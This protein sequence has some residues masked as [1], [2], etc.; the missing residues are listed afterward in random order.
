MHDIFIS[1]RHDGG[2]ETAKFLHDSLTRDGYS[3]AFDIDTLRNGRFDKALL[4]RIDEC[5]DF[6]VI[7]SKGC[8]DRTLNSSYP[9]ENDWLRIE[10]AHAL[11]SK[12]N[13]IPIMLGGFEFPL[14]LPSDISNVALMNGPKYS[15]E[16]FDAFYKKMRDRFLK[17][18]CSPYNNQVDIRRRFGLWR[19]VC[20]TLPLFVA[21]CVGIGVF[22]HWTAERRGKDSVFDI[23]SKANEQKGNVDLI[24]KEDGFLPLVEELCGCFAKAELLY[25]EGKWSDA[26]IAYTNYVKRC[27]ELVALDGERQAAKLAESQARK[28]L[29]RASVFDAK[30]HAVPDWNRAVAML[31]T[32]EDEFRLM[33]FALSRDRFGI[34]ARQFQECAFVAE[35]EKKRLE[36]ERLERQRVEEQARLELEALAK[37][38]REEE[39]RRNLAAKQME[40]AKLAKLCA[41]I[42]VK[43]KDAKNTMEQI[44][45]FRVDPVGFKEHIDNADEQWKVVE[46]VE[47]NPATVARA[48]AELK[49]VEESE[50]V[51]RNELAWLMANKPARDEAKLVEIEIA[52]VIEPELKQVRADNYANE[53]LFA[54]KR[55]RADGNAALA[56][57]DFP[58]S[59]KILLE[60]KAKLS[61]ALAEARSPW[62]SD[63]WKKVEPEVLSI[64]LEYEKHASRNLLVAY[65]P[66]KWFDVDD[67]Q[68]TLDLMRGTNVVERMPKGSESQCEEDSTCRRIEW[69]CP[70]KRTRG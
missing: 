17:S 70:A 39:E 18:S 51:I 54:G 41:R 60:A 14:N 36:Q 15:H 20:A 8:F 57:G 49:L 44:A 56:R 38:R 19:T 11:K 32:A 9:P 37:R 27:T 26:A 1:Y 52:R 30:T 35:K 13:I 2:F 21:L 61:E 55:L 3:V 23:R 43:V 7:L 59:K 12:K 42:K 53:T 64:R 40:A 5:K 6:I 63:M 46:V 28:E 48:E 4:S 68:L 29:Q 66:Q 65:V 10:L 31:E 45:V 47:T 58:V 50:S 24:S 33:E 34:S 69:K 25:N 22:V 67:V 16:Y 62:A